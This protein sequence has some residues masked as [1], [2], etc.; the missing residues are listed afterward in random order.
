[1]SDNQYNFAVEFVEDSQSE[2]DRQSRDEKQEK[3]KINTAVSSTEDTSSEFSSEEISISKMSFTEK[4][5]TDS[6]T[7]QQKS[8]EGTPIE[9]SEVKEVSEL[10]F[11][12]TNTEEKAESVSTVKLTSE[13][14]TTPREGNPAEV[15]NLPPSAIP[16]TEPAAT[17]TGDK[18]EAESIEEEKKEVKTEAK[19][20]KKEEPKS[21]QPSEKSVSTPSVKRTGDSPFFKP[22]DT[23]AALHTAKKLQYQEDLC[24]INLEKKIQTSWNDF[25]GRER[26]ERIGILMTADANKKA[27]L[28]RRYMG[29]KTLEQVR[30]KLDFDVRADRQNF[31]K[32]VMKRVA[33]QIDGH[34]FGNASV[35]SAFILLTSMRRKSGCVGVKVDVDL[36]NVKANALVT[37]DDFCS[38]YVLFDSMENANKFCQYIAPDFQ[39]ECV[40]LVARAQAKR[41]EEDDHIL[42]TDVTSLAPTISTSVIAAVVPTPTT[43]AT[44]TANSLQGDKVEQKET[45][46]EEKELH[47]EEAKEE[48]VVEPPKAKSVEN[49]VPVKKEEPVKAEKVTSAQNADEERIEEYDVPDDYSPFK[50]DMLDLAIQCLNNAL[51]YQVH[52]DVKLYPQGI[53]G[54]VKGLTG[55]TPE[56]SAYANSRNIMNSGYNS[57]YSGYSSTQRQGAGGK[58][59]Q[60]F[61]AVSLV[62]KTVGARV[63]QAKE[64]VYYNCTSLQ[65]LR[66]L[67]RLDMLGIPPG[68]RRLYLGHQLTF[69]SHFEGLGSI[70]ACKALQLS[71][72]RD[73]GAVEVLLGETNSSNMTGI[74]VTFFDFDRLRCT[75]SSQEK[76][77]MFVGYMNQWYDVGISQSSNYNRYNTRIPPQ[78]SYGYGYP[79][80]Y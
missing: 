80:R 70:M 35:A 13:A 29:L 42:D 62:S 25:T 57:S 43:S 51:V 53:K 79:R 56:A 60:G 64:T 44:S 73:S 75:F 76:A 55:R 48:V 7:F 68:K 50:E 54:F 67:Q 36:D 71:L 52:E 23:F 59:S 12:E 2:D 69:P 18:C 20:V 24:A 49:E 72:S 22:D 14:N 32:R 5:E 6:F 63:S 39:G 37:M 77:E 28:L 66:R 19:E 47:V 40:D 10:K 16:A 34:T 46:A 26:S 3:E 21:G 11:S 9:E 17:S 27:K 65:R 8:S 1:M 15:G 33:S 74:V 41:E 38:V 61:N 31:S 4:Q 58:I 78:Q 30:A 45:T